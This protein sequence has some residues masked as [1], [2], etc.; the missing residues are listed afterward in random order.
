MQNYDIS[1]EN[2]KKA[3][4]EI[5]IILRNSEYKVWS[6]IPTNFIRFIKKNMDKNYKVDIDFSKN[7]ESQIKSETKAILSLLYTNYLNIK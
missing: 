1:N 7:I 2:Y 5:Y 6:N 4:S 3:L